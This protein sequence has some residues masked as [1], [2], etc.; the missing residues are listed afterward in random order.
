MLFQFNVQNSFG[1]VLAQALLVSF[2]GEES[3]GMRLLYSNTEG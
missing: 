3:L 1:T 2:P